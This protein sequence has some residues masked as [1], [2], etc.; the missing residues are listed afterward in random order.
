MPNTDYTPLT[1]PHC[2]AMLVLARPDRLLFNNGCYCESKVTL[3]C[4]TCGAQRYW[5]PE[6]TIDEPVTICYANSVPA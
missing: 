4:S 6:R 5:Q 3:R 1:C 2:K